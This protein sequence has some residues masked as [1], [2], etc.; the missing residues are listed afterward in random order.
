MIFKIFLFPN[1]FYVGGTEHLN[2]FGSKWLSNIVEMALPDTTRRPIT[3]KAGQPQML[4]VI[5][6]NGWEIKVVVQE[7]METDPNLK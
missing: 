6:D 3:Y 1:T 7:R 5:V 4:F 2:N